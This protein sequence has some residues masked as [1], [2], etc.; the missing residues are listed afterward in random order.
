MTEI[1]ANVQSQEKECG[2]TLKN[3]KDSSTETDPMKALSLHWEVFVTPGIPIVT[4]SQ[5]AEVE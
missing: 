4:P 5:D 3:V 2:V 1:S